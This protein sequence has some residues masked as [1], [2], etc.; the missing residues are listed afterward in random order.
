MEFSSFL[1]PLLSLYFAYC[2]AIICHSFEQDTLWTVYMYCSLLWYSLAFNSSVANYKW[3]LHVN[4]LFKKRQTLTLAP[5]KETLSNIHHRLLHKKNCR[6]VVC[7]RYVLAFFS[8]TY[9]K[10]SLNIL[11]RHFPDKNPI[12]IEKFM[13]QGRVTVFTPAH[14][15]A[16]AC[17]TD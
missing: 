7:Q 1:L 2:V 14:V 5:I 8:C 9:C 10:N 3:Y 6:L 12:N 15:R 4:F 13:T 17:N 16:P 11:L